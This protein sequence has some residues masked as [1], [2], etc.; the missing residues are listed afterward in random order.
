MFIGNHTIYERTVAIFSY[1]YPLGILKISLWIRGRY[2][3]AMSQV[4]RVD[5]DL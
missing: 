4:T 2:P 3:Y 5:L 1:K